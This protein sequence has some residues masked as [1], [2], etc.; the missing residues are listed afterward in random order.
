MR[1]SGRSLADSLA[2]NGA[3]SCLHLIAVPRY[4]RCL[5]PSPYRWVC[6]AGLHHTFAVPTFPLHPCSGGR[7]RRFSA[8]VGLKASGAD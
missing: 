4:R 5:N 8:A 7:H 6:S 2:S 3:E 1:G